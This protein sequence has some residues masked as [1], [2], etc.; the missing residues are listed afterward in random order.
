MKTPL[1][2]L[3]FA[4]LLAVLLAGCAGN[5][6]TGGS[7]PIGEVDGWV[8]R[9]TRALL[10]EGPTAVDGIAT[11]MQTP[12]ELELDNGTVLRTKTDDVGY[13]I[14]RHV[15]KGHFILRAGDVADQFARMEVEFNRQDDRAHVQLTLAPRPTATADT[16]AQLAVN[17]NAVTNAHVGDSIIFTAQLTGP[18]GGAL[19]VPVSWAV[20]GDIGTI[21]LQAD[22]LLRGPRGVF[23]ATK[24][25]TGTVVVQYRDLP[26]TL[27]PV[28]VLLRETP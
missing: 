6:L 5:S 28:T 13:F 8:Y 2:L 21:A 3:A 24:A 23:K 26:P 25:G 18:L 7:V 10:M 15:P 12:V 11:Q 16:P 1:F 17:P 22:T 14:F 27:V 9:S 20:R 19:D 4:S